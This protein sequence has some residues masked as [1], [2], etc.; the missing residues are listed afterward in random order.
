[1]LK[2]DCI[3][4]LKLVAILLNCDKFSAKILDRSPPFLRLHFLVLKNWFHSLI[5]DCWIDS[6]SKDPE[7]NLCASRHI[8][9]F[10]V[11]PAFRQCLIHTVASD[12]TIESQMSTLKTFHINA[13]IILKDSRYIARIKTTVNLD[14]SLC[15]PKLYLAQTWLII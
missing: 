2:Y 14:S 1:M 4:V 9:D 10:E 7:S 8:R 15:H 11:E 6:D 3:G 13:W 12:L 5:K